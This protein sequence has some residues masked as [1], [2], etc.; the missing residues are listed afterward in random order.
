MAHSSLIRL[1][2][3]PPF[4]IE[5]VDAGWT[6]LTGYTPAH[7]VGHTLQL[8]HGPATDG[9]AV[10]ALGDALRAGKA[11][12]VEL[13]SYH[14]N[15]SPFMNVMTTNPT[16]GSTITLSCVGRPLDQAAESEPTPASGAA[17][18]QQ[19]QL[20]PPLRADPSMPWGEA[21]HV[22]PV[23]GAQPKRAR[24]AS[25]PIQPGPE[26]DDD[27]LELEAAA[28]PS[29]RAREVRARARRAAMRSPP[30]TSSVFPAHAHVRRAPASV[31]AELCRAR[32]THRVRCPLPCALLPRAQA[33]ANPPHALELAP[34][35][36]AAS[37]PAPFERPASPALPKRSR[38]PERDAAAPAEREARDEAATAA[39]AFLRLAHGQQ[40]RPRFEAAEPSPLL[41]QR[42]LST[43]ARAARP[44]DGYCAAAALAPSSASL[45]ATPRAPQMAIG[46]AHRAG[47]GGSGVG[48]S[49]VGGSELSAGSGERARA[50]PFVYKLDQM[51]SSSDEQTARHIHWSA[52]GRSILVVE[53]DTFAASVLPRYFKH[54]HLTS[55]TQQLATY[56]FTRLRQI[57]AG[58]SLAQQA[59]CVLEYAHPQ[60]WRGSSAEVLC[61]IRRSPAVGKGRRS[62]P[63]HP[64]ASPLAH[65]AVV[66]APQHMV[67]GEAAWR[68]PLPPLLQRQP[69]APSSA[70]PGPQQ[71]AAAGGP[72]AAAP[73]VAGMSTTSRAWVSEVGKML[74]ELEERFNRYVRPR[75][76]RSALAGI[77]SKGGRR[78]GGAARRAS[79]LALTHAHTHT[80]S[81]ACSRSRDPSRAATVPLIA[82]SAKQQHV[83]AETR[84]EILVLQIAKR[85]RPTR[86]LALARSPSRRLAV[87][88]F[89]RA[90]LLARGL[91]GL[92]WSPDPLGRA[93]SLCL[94]SCLASC[95]SAEDCS[96]LTFQLG[97][98]GACA[99]ARAH[100]TT[101]ARVMR[102]AS[103]ITSDPHRRPPLPRP[104]AS[105][106]R[107][108]HHAELARA[109]A[110]ARA[111]AA[112]QTQQPPP[113]GRRLLRAGEQSRRADLDRVRAGQVL[114]GRLGRLL[115]ER[116]QARAG[117]GRLGISGHRLA[118]RERRRRRRRRRLLRGRRAVAA[119]RAGRA[120]LSR[121]R[122]P[123]GMPA[124]GRSLAGGSHRR[125]SSTGLVASSPGAQETR[126]TRSLGDADA[127]CCRQ[128][129]PA[130]S[131]SDGNAWQITWYLITGAFRTKRVPPVTVYIPAGNNASEVYR[132]S[133]WKQCQRSTP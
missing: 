63:P 16:A 92:A 79:S 38:S 46:G 90:R 41:L 25:P 45:G 73:L 57:V 121:R 54:N 15:G 36:P 106:A 40:A 64:Q 77:F 78:E 19:Q 14:M 18:P 81:L 93:V 83:F 120:G 125:R 75:P 104:A 113:R 123:R 51:L 116:H 65:E 102:H 61:A 130:A 1:D 29:A 11:T 80:H 27:A 49:C 124:T 76:R 39:A 129:Q 70:P 84:L 35:Q 60:L 43:S 85:V 6:A 48:G 107:A 127:R 23:V 96:G 32:P 109:P 42:S 118:R 86:A 9:A 4:P 12:V 128:L 89:K 67:D 10:R 82:R 105:I 132:H 58:A 74:D 37:K 114:G 33:T 52:H 31:V 3:K 53:P 119:G 5:E 28:H 59:D 91:R 13:V 69:S 26:P 20:P 2:E 56:G 34:H 108:A 21:A 87:S 30:P 97:S 95:L 8:L 71:Q 126:S 50:A 100:A 17:A 110:R 22:W 24:L 131:A 7:T 72:L 103:R 133:D 47:V 101:L 115:R 68:P 111:G 122:A 44:G 99:R 88:L 112:I 94:P 117:R 62:Q 66:G 55:F 98:T